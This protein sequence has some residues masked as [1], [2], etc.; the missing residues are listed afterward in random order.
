[1]TGKRRLRAIDKEPLLFLLITAILAAAGL[2]IHAA[3][4]PKGNR[5]EM[6]D[7]TLIVA[8]DIHYIA[9]ELTDHG[10]YF[11]RMIE[12][13]DGKVMEYIEELTDAFLSEV[14]ARHPDALILSGDLTFNGARLSHEVLAEK[15][16]SVANAGIPVLVIPGNH[17]LE[18]EDAAC[19]RGE[20]FTRVENVTAEDFAD[21]YHDLGP[22][23]AVSSDSASL[24]YIVQI[25]P[26]LRIL[27]LD[28]NT[29]D[30]PD[31]VG[32]GTLAWVEDQ[33]RA[34]ASEG[35]KV[36]AVSHQNLY[37]HNPVIYQGYVIENADALL[38]LY[39]KYGVPVNL[40]GHLHCQ[41]IVK[42]DVCDIATSSLAVAPC[43]YG[44]IT[45][46]DGVLDYGTVPVDVSSRAAEQG[47]TDPELLHFAEYAEAFFLRSG[48]TPIDDSEPDADSLTR[49]FGDLNLKYFAGRLDLVDP[50]DPMFDR[51]ADAF[52]FEGQYIMAIRDEAGLNSTQ[53]TISY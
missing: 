41:H 53:L 39:E 9:P 15:L 51:W 12:N 36:I 3:A 29:T 37:R 4:A 8:T 35:I 19:F 49:F 11:E 23:Q 20:S 25:G 38:S 24:S 2:G 52:G 46:S 1:M 14:I 18:N 50:E 7:I 21:I 45:L 5:S 31:R 33:L 13:S 30:S 42:G 48:R 34:A 44:V 28:V 6:T 22:G 43:Q 10:E 16:R 47:S 32:K 17:D 27:M 26:S 40:S